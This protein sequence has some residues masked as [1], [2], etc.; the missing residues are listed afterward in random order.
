MIGAMS[1]FGALLRCFPRR[2]LID[3]PLSFALEHEVG[4]PRLE[5]IA[6]RNKA[7]RKGRKVVE[8]RG[9]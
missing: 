7:K 3:G 4:V 9:F 5:A 1:G 2:S 8:T 6:T